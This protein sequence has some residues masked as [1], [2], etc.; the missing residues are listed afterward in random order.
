MKKYANSMFALFICMLILAPSTVYAEEL[1]AMPVFS[2]IQ[3]ITGA[4]LSSEAL[5]ESLTERLNYYLTDSFTNGSIDI[6][7]YN[8]IL[9]SGMVSENAF[10][11]NSV[12]VGDSLTVGF[13]QYCRTHDS[14]ASD[15]TYFLARVSCSAKAAISDNALT[16]HAGIMPIYNG[17]VQYIEDSVSQIPNV[18]K[19]FI[20]YG[21]NDLTGSTPDQF[22]AD[23]QTLIGRITAKT[24][25]LQVYVISIPCV[26]S[27][28][29]T[30][31]LN[32]NTIQTANILLQNTCAANGWG[33]INISEYLMG[34][35]NAIRP[36]YSS[37]HYVHENNY[38]YQVWNKVLKDYAFLEI[39]K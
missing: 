13:E 28:V 12:F 38:A 14:I 27:D 2:V 34:Q 7:K 29:H 17:K 1:A 8:D 36:E 30:G 3:P 6:Q 21:M 11:A 20:C 26:M 16:K 37:D 9:S 24:P 5:P 33:Y 4:A 18:S 15:S 35:G 31:G 39:T 10:F 19:M 25:D 32:N 23:L 22:V